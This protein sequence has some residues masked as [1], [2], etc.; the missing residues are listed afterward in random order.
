VHTDS[1]FRHHSFKFHKTMVRF[2][3]E[4]TISLQVVIFISCC[5]RE[6][7]SLNLKGNR[8]INPYSIGNNININ[9][10]ISSSNSIREIRLQALTLGVE[11]DSEG[12]IQSPQNAEWSSIMTPSTPALAKMTVADKLRL[13]TFAGCAANAFLVL[14]LKS[15]PGSWRFF[16]AGGLCA[17]ISHTIPTP[18]DVVKVSEKTFG[19]IDF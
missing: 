9:T 13:A 2:L 18:V 11:N 19:R 3:S 12:Y 5:C 16:L 1:R 17:A 7:T 14:V 6:S 15:S 10:L 4:F 8:R